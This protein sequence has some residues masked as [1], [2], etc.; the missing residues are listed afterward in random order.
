MVLTTTTTIFATW[1][2]N[3]TCS[4]DFLNRPLVLEKWSVLLW[5]MQCTALFCQAQC[6][7]RGKKTCA[8]THAIW[9][10]RIVRAWNQAANGESFFVHIMLLYSTNNIPYCLLLITKPS[11]HL[12][13]IQPWGLFWVSINC[14]YLCMNEWYFLF[15]YA[16]AWY[17]TQKCNVYT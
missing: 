14:M 8:R 6:H 13:I 16:Y 17:F 9:F 10:Y 12:A 7:D 1:L 15:I 5:M 4:D 11:S 2:T 3:F